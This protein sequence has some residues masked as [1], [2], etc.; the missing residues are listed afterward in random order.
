MYRAQA[1]WRVSSE[2]EV[3]VSGLALEARIRRR[4]RASAELLLL[5]TSARSRAFTP[6][7]DRERREQRRHAAALSPATRSRPASRVRRAAGGQQVERRT[8]VWDSAACVGP[9]RAAR[10]QGLEPGSTKSRR[11]NREQRRDR[12]R[13]GM[14]PTMRGRSRPPPRGRRETINL[15]AATWRDLS[16]AR[17]RLR[18]HRASVGPS[19]AGTRQR[20]SRRLDEV[21]KAVARSR[22][23]RAHTIARARRPG[24][25]RGDER[26]SPSKARRDAADRER[27]EALRHHSPQRLLS[28]TSRSSGLREPGGGDARGAE[29]RPQR[30]SRAADR[31]AGAAAISRQHEGTGLRGTGA[32]THRFARHRAVLERE[33]D[34]CSHHVG[35]RRMRARTNAD[36][37]LCARARSRCASTHRLSGVTPG[38]AHSRS[39]VGSSRQARPDRDRGTR[40]L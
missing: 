37:P 9:G 35:A 8:R 4:A 2:K 25:G 36:R 3:V 34:E 1:R 33:A 19:P 38:I 16:V 18:V 17:G 30:D 10:C 40:R 12:A 28:T 14:R 11:S 6:M 26:R 29:S 7:G 5:R 13:A 21:I 31:P 15:E 20:A 27:L 24:Q 32:A 23:D 39:R 22:I